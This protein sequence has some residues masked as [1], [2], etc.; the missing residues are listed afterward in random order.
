MFVDVDATFNLK[1]YLLANIYV[2]VGGV[3]EFSYDSQDAQ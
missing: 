1:L 3:T 2:V